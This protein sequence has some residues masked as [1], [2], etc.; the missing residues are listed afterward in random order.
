MSYQ[1]YEKLSRDR[2]TASF[3]RFSQEL[4]REIEQ[5]GV[6]EEALLDELGQTKREVYEEQY[7]RRA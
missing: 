5:Q 2:A 3:E 7:G 4:G 6:T 1:E